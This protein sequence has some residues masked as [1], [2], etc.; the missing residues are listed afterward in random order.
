M[1]IDVFKY[2]SDDF[3]PNFNNKRV[4]AS[5]ITMKD[6]YRVA[7]WGNDNCGFERNFKSKKNAFKLF[8]ELESVDDITIQILK[9]MGFRH[10]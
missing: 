1:R 4:R 8:K 10:A 2:T 6:E 7:V 9:K 5:F 3:Y